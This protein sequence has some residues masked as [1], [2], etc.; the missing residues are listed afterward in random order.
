MT[1]KL[2]I[3][4]HHTATL[5]VADPV[6]LGQLL[7]FR[8]RCYLVTSVSDDTAHARLTYGATK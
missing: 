4:G 1:I 2:T 5:R 3:N 6:R 7:P 8:G